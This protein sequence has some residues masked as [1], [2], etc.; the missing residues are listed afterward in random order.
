MLD[1]YAD[2]VTRLPTVPEVLS[3]LVYTIPVQLFAYHV[4]MAKFRAAERALAR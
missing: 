1:P 3:A 2:A 4:A